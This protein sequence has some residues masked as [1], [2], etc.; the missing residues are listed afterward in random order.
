LHTVLS[1]TAN[2]FTINALWAD[3]TNAAIDGEVTYADFRK[4]ITP[5]D[6]IIEDREVFNGA[7]NNLI[8]NTGGVFPVADYLGVAAGIQICSD[9]SY[10]Q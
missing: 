3:V 1:A 8:F 4:T 9:Y 7:Y 6:V 5:K 2:D 10:S